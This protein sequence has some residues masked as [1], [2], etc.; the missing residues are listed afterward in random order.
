MVACS[1]DTYRGVWTTPMLETG[2]TGVLM[3]NVPQA[4][5]PTQCT[6]PS[7]GIAACSR[8]HPQVRHTT[9]ASGASTL[10]FRL[11]P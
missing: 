11:A 5:S 1:E 3:T 2:R 9:K 7:V 4:T 8:Q 10:P 6:H